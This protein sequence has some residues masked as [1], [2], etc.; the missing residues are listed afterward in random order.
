MASSCFAQEQPYYYLGGSV[1]QSQTNL[2]A[3]HMTQAQLGS[4]FNV[5]SI[6]RDDKDTAYKLFGGYQFNRFYALEGGFFYLGKPHFSADTT[7]AGTLNGQV[8][9]QG[10]NMDVVGLLPMTDKLSALARLGLIYT[11][12]TD[13]F[14]GTG[15]AVP[16][17][18]N[19]RRTQTSYKGG[20]G[21]QYEVSPSFLIRAEIERYRVSDAMDNHNGVNV[22]SV[23]L[24]FPIGRSPAPAKQA[25]AEPAP[26]V[27]Q[28]PA[29]QQMPPPVV[30]APE[31]VAPPPLRKRVTFSAESLFTFNQSAVQPAGQ[32]ALDTFA[33]DL[34]GTQFDVV[35]VEGHTDRIGSPA[36]NQRLS[37]ERAQAVKAYLVESGKVDPSKISA[38]GKGESAPITKPGECKGHKHTAKLIAC[39]QPDRR[40]EIE[41]VGTR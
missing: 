27:A 40:V 28:A 30:A 3:D 18:T 39:L 10:W 29:P 2:E 5:D 15:A 12:T 34:N 26:Y 37:E 36:Y 1:G 25:V 38:S 33:K 6:K 23:S 7:P 35:N 11:T 14:T 9:M 20:L 32:G 4:G 13:R 17:E 22:A 24:V 16:A 31:P 19:P 8:K 21:L 41:V